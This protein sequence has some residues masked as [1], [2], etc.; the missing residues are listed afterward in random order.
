MPVLATIS[1][2]DIDSSHILLCRYGKVL[3]HIF[4]FDSQMPF[5]NAFVCGEYRHELYIAKNSLR[6]IRFLS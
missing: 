6:D 4:I 1:I 5:F 2:N 3:G